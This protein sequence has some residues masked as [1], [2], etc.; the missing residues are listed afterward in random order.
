VYKRQAEG[1]DRQLVEAALTVLPERERRIVELRFFEE[2]SQSEIADEMGMSQM[3]V[4]RLLRRSFKDMRAHLA[5]DDGDG[6][7]SD[8][9]G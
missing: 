7:T 6:D 2:K 1:L 5:G 3:H 9:A 8:P 4:S